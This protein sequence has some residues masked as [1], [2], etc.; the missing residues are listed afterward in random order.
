MWSRRPIPSGSCASTLCDGREAAGRPAGDHECPALQS[1][2]QEIST[3]PP[4]RSA[5]AARIRR[6]LPTERPRQPRWVDV[7]TRFRRQDETDA[8][9]HGAVEARLVHPRLTEV[10]PRR[11]PAESG[12]E[13]LERQPDTL[14]DP[15]GVRRVL[16]PRTIYE[17][18]P[19]RVGP[20]AVAAEPRRSDLVIE[21][22][23]DIVGTSLPDCDLGVESKSPRESRAVP[24]GG[25]GIAHC[26]DRGEGERYTLPSGSTP[27]GGAV[28][29]GLDVDLDHDGRSADRGPH[30]VADSVR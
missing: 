12:A 15:G 4:I 6:I 5:Q 23:Q 14:L 28:V 17:S 20:K 8:F 11:R 18:V 24:H 29:V 27:S 22:A 21:F 30:S 25:K 10:D 16:H 19:V 3:T 7:H 13:G 9:V 26:T 1:T 2:A